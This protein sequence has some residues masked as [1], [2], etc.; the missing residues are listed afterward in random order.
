MIK[1]ARRTKR[2]TAKSSA[3]DI[4]DTS[5]STFAD[6]F[7]FARKAANMG[8]PTLMR[9]VADAIGT[10]EELSPSL[11]STIERK[12]QKSSRYNDAFAKVLNVNQIWLATGEGPAPKEFDA[13][14]ARM[15]RMN[16]AVRNRRGAPIELAGVGDG[17][18]PSWAAPEEN[19]ESRLQRKQAELTRDLIDFAILAGPE[20]MTGFLRSVEPLL[21]TFG[22]KSEGKDQLRSS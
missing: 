8:S 13:V 5:K 18:A 11:V 22:K 12:D 6:R 20:R 1:R 15:G 4:M 9:L 7:W 19:E 16:E 14:K 17:L 21:A 2:L 10:K 3:G